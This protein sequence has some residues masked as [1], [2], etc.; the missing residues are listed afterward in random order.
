VNRSPRVYD[1]IANGQFILTRRDAYAAV[2]GHAAVRDTVAEDLMLAQ[3]YFAAGRRVVLVEGLDQL[4]TR[5]YTSLPELVRGWMKNI[6]AG[7]VHALPPSRAVRA[8]HPLLV[9]AAPILSLLPI[10]VLV[11]G[12][13]GVGDRVTP[14]AAALAVAFS[15]VWWA[16]VYLAIGLSPVYALAYPLGSAVLLYICVRAVARGR[17]VVWKGREY[18]TR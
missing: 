12:A 13:L 15:L 1:K 11:L 5:M 17:R 2:G 6:Y 9:L 10:V 8:L 14:L 16:V 7:S 18:V 3:R 4:A